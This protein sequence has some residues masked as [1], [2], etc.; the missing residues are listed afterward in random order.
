MLDIFTV[1]GHCAA[2][3]DP[4]VVV[5]IRGSYDRLGVIVIKNKNKK[6]Q[7]NIIYFLSCV[8]HC[9]YEMHYYND[10]YSSGVLSGC[11]C[12]LKA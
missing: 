7:F 1:H 12:N 8:Y 10:D 5:V 9:N 6:K 2:A 11:V 3:P 4:S